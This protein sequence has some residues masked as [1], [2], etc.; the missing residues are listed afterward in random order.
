MITFNNIKGNN[1]LAFFSLS[2][3]SDLSLVVASPAPFF[4]ISLRLKVRKYHKNSSVLFCYVNKPIL[5]QLYNDGQEAENKVY[6]WLLA[7]HYRHPLSALRLSNF[8]L[9][10]CLDG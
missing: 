2:V 4:S 8:D 6:Q 10:L 9:G 3:R 7:Y 1:K 5:L